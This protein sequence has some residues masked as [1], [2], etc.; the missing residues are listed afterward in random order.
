MS[1]ERT[2][3]P[4][5]LR[6]VAVGLVAAGGAVGTLARYGVTSIVPTL[7][8]LPVAVVA[9]NVAGAFLLGLLTALAP[10]ER[11]RL[12]LGTGVL[13]GFTTYS[14]YAVD[15]Q[16]LV[17][18]HESALALAYLLMTLAGGFAASV[19]GLAAGRRWRR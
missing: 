7:G 16:L 3:P 1:P 15:T 5:H 14:T 6:P 13:G 9:V 10:G 17:A 4:S 2:R 18:R 8:G 12:L 19:L 11:L